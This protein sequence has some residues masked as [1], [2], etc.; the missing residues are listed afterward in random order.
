MELEWNTWRMPT[1]LVGHNVTQ[2][3]IGRVCPSE[4]IFDDLWLASIEAVDIARFWPERL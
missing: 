3:T 2:L 1:W 4:C